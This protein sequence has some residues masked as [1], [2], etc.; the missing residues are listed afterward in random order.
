MDIAFDVKDGPQLVPRGPGFD[1]ASL[2]C[3]V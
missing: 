2:H 1:V 3:T